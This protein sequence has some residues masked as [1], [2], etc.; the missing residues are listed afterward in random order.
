MIAPRAKMP[1]MERCV[2]GVCG[3][4]HR[5]VPGLNPW[6]AGLVVQFGAILPLSTLLGVLPPAWRASRATPA[7]LLSAS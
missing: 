6:D 3:A 7:S 2:S 5:I 1:R 4:D